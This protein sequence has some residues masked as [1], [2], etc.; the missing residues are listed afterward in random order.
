MG[1][2]SATFLGAGSEICD[3]WCDALCW[4]GHEMPPES[5]NMMLSAGIRHDMPPERWRC[6]VRCWA[7]L[8]M[9][10]ERWKCDARHWADH[11]L[12]QPRAEGDAG[13]QVTAPA[14]RYWGLELC[15]GLRVPDLEVEVG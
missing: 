10:P 5:W 8:E 6:E 15:E 13:C 12:L 4:A 3:V 14:R 9:P 7:R 2:F 11:E 1:T